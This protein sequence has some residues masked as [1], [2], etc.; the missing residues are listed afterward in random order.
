MRPAIG[1]RRPRQRRPGFDLAGIVETV[2]EGVDGLRPGDEVF[3][4]GEGAFAEYAVAEESHL[5]ALPAKFSFEQAA[6]F[7]DSAV[8]ALKAVRDQGEVRSG[9]KVLVNGA[10]GGVGTY[11]V[12]IARSFGAEVT[13]VCSTAS[14]ELV[15]SIGADQVIDYTQEDF[16]RG[17]RRYDVILDMAGNRPLSDC[18]RTL[19]PRGTYVLVGTLD[20]G[21]FFGLSRQV[22]MLASSPFVRQRMRVFIATRNREDLMALKQ[23]AEAG[24]LEPV[25]DRSFELNEVPDA[26]RHQ[27]EGHPKGK[28][29]VRAAPGGGLGEQ[30]KRSSRRLRSRAGI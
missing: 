21:R 6:A 27:G 15:R 5:L 25:I 23:L 29:V 30:V 8:T 16:T 19:T 18:R 17:E 10:S 26:L 7:G 11:A 1:L 4:W 14:L 24:E 28:I 22:R 12:Q 9:Q 13:G 3:G 2:G 20:V